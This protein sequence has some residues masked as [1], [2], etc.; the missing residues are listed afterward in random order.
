MG[1]VQGRE[2]G[3]ET[4]CRRVELHWNWI[5]CFLFPFLFPL[6]MHVPFG[7]T[8]QAAKTGEQGLFLCQKEKNRGY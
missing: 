5:L 2:D 8:L 6:Q 1:L 7:P 3:M 4:S